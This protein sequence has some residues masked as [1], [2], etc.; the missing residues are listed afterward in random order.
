MRSTELLID[1]DESD[2][3]SECTRP[4][5]EDSSNKS[6]KQGGVTVYQN[7]I[8]LTQDFSVVRAPE[9]KISAK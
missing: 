4:L 6:K 8:F 7:Q 2:E 9:K 3:L 1:E 5:K